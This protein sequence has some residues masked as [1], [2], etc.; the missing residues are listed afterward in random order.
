MP[1]L[2]PIFNLDHFQVFKLAEY[3]PPLRTELIKSLFK[4]KGAVFVE[5]MGKA[6]VS[7]LEALY[8]LFETYFHFGSFL[9]VQ[10]R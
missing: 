8:A 9:G 2:R 6:C 7:V 1:S 10:T 5:I 4:F 3:L